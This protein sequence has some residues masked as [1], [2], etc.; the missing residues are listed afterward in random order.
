MEDIL[1]YYS[2]NNIT[3]NDSMFYCNGKRL[4]LY[5][6]KD[7]EIINYNL[8][9]YP[10][11]I[12]L[13]NIFNSYITFYNGKKFVLFSSFFP[14]RIV[15]IKDI[16]YI[17]MINQF[18]TYINYYDVWKNKLN[19]IKK[20]YTNKD[21]YL[22]EYYYSLALNVIQASKNIDYKELSYGFCLKKITDFIDTDSFYN[23]C[24]YRIGGV[25]TNISLYIKYVFFN[26]IKN[27][28]INSFL[29]L[30]LSY[31]DFYF[32]LC[33][34]LFPNYYFDYQFDNIYDTFIEYINY[35]KL[36]LK[37]LKKRQSF[38]LSIFSN[39]INLLL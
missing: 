28:D 37:E 10:F 31:D 2:N 15:D 3:I 24:K 34:L 16:N 36:L 39:L 18:K 29:N 4:I 9:R 14:H 21:N 1:L 17:I 5:E 26:K 22:Y 13:L 7:N 33:S 20:Y 32:L 11:H 19:I 38:D 25:V 35:I 27:N 6:L 30:Y 8:M 23:I 12:P